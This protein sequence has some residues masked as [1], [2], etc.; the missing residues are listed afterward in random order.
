MLNDKTQIAKGLISL[1]DF[2]PLEV[3]LGIRLRK[4]VPH[5]HGLALIG[6]VHVEM[7]GAYHLFALRA[8]YMRLL[9]VGLCSLMCVIVL[10][11]ASK[12]FVGSI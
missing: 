3:D 5:G 4:M 9:G 7:L 10:N 8:M 12:A 2:F 6:D 1:D 11:F